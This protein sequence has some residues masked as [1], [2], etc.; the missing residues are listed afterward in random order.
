MDAPQQPAPSLGGDRVLLHADLDG[1]YAQV[2]AR[3]LGL[4]AQVTP[5]GVLQWNS[6][7][8]LSYPAKARGVTRMM[9]GTEARRACPELRLAHVEVI[10]TDGRRVDDPVADGGA[11]R[12]AFA[13]VHSECKASLRRYR[14]ASAE[15]L[16]ALSA[17]AKERSGGVVERASIDEA[18]IDVTAAAEALVSAGEVP[19]LRE[20]WALVGGRV[21]HGDAPLVAG[22][23]VAEELRAAVRRAT[24]FTMSVGVARNRPLA[25]LA[26]SRNKPDKVSVVPRGAAEALLRG[27]KL[28]DLNGLGGK[29]GRS[30]LAAFKLPDEATAGDVWDVRLEAFEQAL[31]ADSARYVH[32]VLRGKGQ[33]AVTSNLRVKQCSA[34][35]SFEASN[36]RAA[37]RKWVHALADEVGER[38]IT[39]RTRRG[40]EAR[41]LALQFRPAGRGADARGERSKQCRL[42]RPTKADALPAAVRAAADSLL[43]VAF[44]SCPLSRLIVTARDFDECGTAGRGAGIGAL[45]A[46]ATP[47]PSA[48]APRE[49][50]A[51]AA[52]QSV[53]TQGPTL[54]IPPNIPAQQDAEQLE[55]LELEEPSAVEST[56]A[57]GPFS[58]LS[59]VASS[60]QT[61]AALGAASG[62][63]VADAHEEL[64]E[65]NSVDKA[66]QRLLMA[67]F[68]RQRRAPTKVPSPAAKR[69][70]RSGGGGGNK[71]SRRPTAGKQQSVAAFFQAKLYE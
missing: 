6:L 56:A 37:L 66:E 3:R 17:A 27:V 28:T 54:P 2:E 8:A 10:Y 60:K 42:R 41:T 71:G 68:E 40:R 63:T 36:N 29:L 15:V 11:G 61:P 26:S 33:D 4:D 20:A 7:I 51:A 12:P 31:G 32:A 59:M 13:G 23:A 5:I 34:A 43:E 53:T 55:S 49:E 22:C 57:A 19:A 16:D 67:Q 24:G 9:R 70:R 62:T 18:Y 44:A 47:A 52:E 21:E 30:V 45:F 25:K 35:K 48:G 58:S 1:F 38:L 65:L 69:R 64:V 50:K 46:R 39:E 14:D